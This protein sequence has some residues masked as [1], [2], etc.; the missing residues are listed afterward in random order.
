MR[1]TSKKLGIKPEARAYLK[2]VPQAIVP[3]LGLSASQIAKRL[4]GEFQYIHLFATR[5]TELC[6]LLPKLKAHLSPTG[7]LWVSWPKGK[8]LDSD[9]T[10]R[11][12]IRIGYDFGLVE[13]KTISIDA[14]WSAIKFTRPKPNKKY[15]NSF[16]KLP[17]I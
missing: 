13:S 9:V 17:D 6:R 14:T 11:D 5:Q 3:S 2:G 8:T 7:T 1:S 4:T 15:Q 10:I 16:G 12:V